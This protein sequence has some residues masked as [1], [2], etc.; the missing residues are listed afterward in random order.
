MCIVY[1]RYIGIG[2]TIIRDLLFI[3]VLKVIGKNWKNI[4]YFLPNI[5]I[6]LRKITSIILLKSNYPKCI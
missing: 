1:K 3:F 5:G 6:F 4:F 2:I